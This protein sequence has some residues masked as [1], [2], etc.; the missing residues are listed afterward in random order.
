MRTVGRK[1]EGRGFTIAYPGREEDRHLTV[2][3]EAGGHCGL[4]VMDTG[5]VQWEWPGPEGRRPDP[6]QI[7]GI[8]AWLLT[9]NGPEYGHSRAVYSG[10]DLTVKGCPFTGCS[11]L[12]L[13][14]CREWR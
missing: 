10:K 13:A 4:S 8:S 7:T 11:E 2:T 9:G 1:L 3:S 6:N 12:G 14:D 5:S